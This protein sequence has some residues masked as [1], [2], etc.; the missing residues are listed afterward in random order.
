VTIAEIEGNTYAFI[1]LERVGGVMVYN[2]SNPQAAS[3]VQ[4]INPRDF[5]VDAEDDVEIVGDLGPESIVFIPAA[6]SPSGE[7]LLL[8]SNE[9]SGT[10]A[11]FS[12]TAL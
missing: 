4:Y 6:D 5:T 7:P 10:L 8:V 1:G 9:V 12:V 11:V 3:F 2:I